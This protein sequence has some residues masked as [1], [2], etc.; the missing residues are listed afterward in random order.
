MNDTTDLKQTAQML[1][2]DLASSYDDVLDNL[3]L[4]Q[5]RYW[6]KFLVEKSNLR[7]GQR[8]LDLA[9]GTCVLEEWPGIDGCDVI[10]LDLSERMV[11]RG[12]KKKIQSV[13]SLIRADAE[14]LPFSDASFDVVLSCYLPK[15][16][17][18]QKLVGEIGRVLSPGGTTTVYDFSRPSGAFAPFHAFYV[19]V[20]LKLLAG[21]AR[22]TFGEVEYTFARL[23]GIIRK[24]HW[25]EDWRGRLGQ[26]EF[27][28][29]GEKA[30]TGGVVTVI[31]ARRA[32]R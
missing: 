20:V 30:L 12:L 9:C 25:V 23:P 17:N 27:E 22:R 2:R 14:S 18:A 29:V 26:G 5:D 7:R 16:C 11:R 15:Y 8:V 10:G 4:R 6:K 32:D 3:T 21:I 24:T 19:Y 28:E 13:S 1:F 31:W